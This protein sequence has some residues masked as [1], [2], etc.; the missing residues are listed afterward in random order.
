MINTTKK[1]YVKRHELI[2]GFFIGWWLA[3]FVFSA[4][5]Y[6]WTAAIVSLLLGWTSY[7]ISKIK[8]Q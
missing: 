5:S 8:I 3:V 2:S 6:F 7:K 1:W 4:V